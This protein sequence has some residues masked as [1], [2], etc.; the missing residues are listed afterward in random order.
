MFALTSALGACEVE[1]WIELVVRCWDNS[2]NTQPLDVRNSW[3]WGLHVTQSCHRVK[4]YSV[5]K[6]REM[7]RRRLNE[8]AKQG[9]SLVPITRPT[10]FPTITMDE[11]EEYWAKHEPR[12]VD[13]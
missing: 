8:F 13:E 3:N 10:D 7:T 5:N 11:Y 1:G 6:S 12:D 9:E 4:I 2:I